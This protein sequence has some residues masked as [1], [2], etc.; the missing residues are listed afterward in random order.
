M[1]FVVLHGH[2]CGV[3]PL[4]PAVVPL[5]G[6]LLE[7]SAEDPVLDSRGHLPG[8]GGDGGVLCRI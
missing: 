7:G 3:H 2:V 1:F 6:L 4:R 8:D 5:G